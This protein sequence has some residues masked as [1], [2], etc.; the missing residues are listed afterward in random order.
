MNEEMLGALDA[1]EKEKGIKKEVVIEAIQAALISAYKRN[2]GQAQN[3]DVEFDQQS[4]NIHV[5]AVKK[6]VDEVA[7]DRLEISL[8]D[9]LKINRAYEVGDD[10]KRE[11]TPK[12][13]GRISAQ[14]AKQVIMQRLREA[15]RSKIFNEYTQ[16]EHEIIQ[17]TVLRRDNKFIYVDL[18]DIEA[19]MGKQDQIPNEDYQ[20]HDRIKVFVSKV[21]NTTKGPQVF[22]SRTN[23]ELVKRLFEQEIPEVYD[24]TVEIVSIAREAGDR[25][26]V[27]VRSTNPNVDPVGTCVGPKGQRVQTIVNELNGENMDIV[28]WEE[29]PSDYIANALNPAEVIAVQ[30]D[31][32][33]RECMVIVPDY[34]L[35]L[36]IGKRGQN[37][38]LAAK[39]TGFKIDI[40]PES[41]VEFVSDDDETAD[42]GADADQTSDQTDATATPTDSE[43]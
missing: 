28:K 13:F 1:L 35:S 38:R 15:E 30:F 37:A 40:K 27:A 14:T 7:D 12:N 21:E 9:A 10:I 39:L 24:G 5:Y 23:P 4:G 34:Q 18:G 8:T 6:V 42:E 33:K 2:Y 31:Q 19:V 17:G 43:E 16:Y 41:E 29:D 20:V 22:V 25:S 32:E 36:A 11:V 3:V 26:K